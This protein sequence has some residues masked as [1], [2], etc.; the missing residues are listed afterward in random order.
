M[1]D[2][3]KL[4]TSLSPFNINRCFPS[5]FNRGPN[6]L[7]WLGLLASFT[8]VFIKLWTPTSINRIPEALYTLP[9]F[10]ILVI[11]FHW[12]KRD[13]IIQ[14]FGLAIVLPI[15]FHGINYLRDPVLALEYEG[16]DKLM[17][18]FF[19]VPIAW[20]LGGNRRTALIFLLIAFAGLLVAMVVHSDLEQQW[21]LIK[22]GIRVDYGIMNAQH[23]AQFFG[24]AL[25]GFLTLG[26]YFK[27]A[28]NTADKSYIATFATIGSLLTAFI[29]LTT[30]TR[31]ALLALAVCGT[32]AFLIY[33]FKRFQKPTNWVSKASILA[34]PVIAILIA[35]PFIDSVTKRFQADRP[36]IDAMVSGDWDNIPASSLGV[37]VNTTLVALDWIAKR[38][39]I[40]W[41]GDVNGYAINSS[42]RL[43]DPIKS[44]FAHFHNTVI[45]FT[46]AYGVLGLLLIFTL[47]YTLVRH[48]FRLPQSNQK[49]SPICQFTLYVVLYFA[50]IN[51][52]ESFLFF[53][54]G[55]FANSI[56]FAPIYTLIL[57]KTDNPK[58]AA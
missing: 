21:G 29:V 45:E 30:Q 47:Y 28:K 8:A 18:L 16:L 51:Q 7:V 50:V 11:N 58:Y 20:W 6:W 48:S 38:P 40:G 35:L 44:S 27:Y 31:A 10:Y 37:R 32:V 24:I 15:V 46:I 33:A 14:L 36:T 49:N 34:I 43:S 52:F 9:F 56:A 53:Y 4:P 23:G 13:R 5:K 39:L 1:A 42:E 19:F 57:A 26:S 25:I 54:S 12:L 55:V 41:G 2:S 3:S 22:R 17:K